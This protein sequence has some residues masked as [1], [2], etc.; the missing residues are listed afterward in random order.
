MKIDT[1]WNK[2]LATR[3]R[4]A[5]I[6]AGLNQ[7]QASRLLECSQSYVSMMESGDRIP[8]APLIARVCDIYAVDGNWL[9][10]L[11]DE[12]DLDPKWIEEIRKLSPADRVKMRKMLTMIGQ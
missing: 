1:G 6:A 12:E 2:D 7:S 11:H 10:G 9:L 3:L 8:D 4:D 5:R